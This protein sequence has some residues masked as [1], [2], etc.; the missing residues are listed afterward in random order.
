MRQ[1]SSTFLVQLQG[2]RS[3]TACSVSQFHLQNININ[4]SSAVSTIRFS[5]FLVVLNTV[6]LVVLG[7]IQ[8]SGCRKG[9][10]N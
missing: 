9:A 8:N 6:D 4:K 5:E 1:N 10:M 3:L 7:S 2:S